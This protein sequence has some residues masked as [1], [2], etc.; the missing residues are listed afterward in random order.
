MVKQNQ[1]NIMK[2]TKKSY[3]KKYEI[4]KEEKNKIE[5]YGRNRYKNMSEKSKKPKG[6]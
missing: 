4:V 5:E 1:K 6:I 3:K 2:I